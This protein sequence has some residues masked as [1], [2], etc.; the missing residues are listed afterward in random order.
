MPAPTATFTPDQPVQTRYLLVW[1]TS[2]PQTSS[3]DHYRGGDRRHRG[4][5]VS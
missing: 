5:W 2:L 1:L 4:H 3:G